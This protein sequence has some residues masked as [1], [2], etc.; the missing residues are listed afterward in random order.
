MQE[1]LTEQKKKYDIHLQTLAKLE[2]IVILHVELVTNSRGHCLKK[3]GHFLRSFFLKKKKMQ[4]EVKYVKMDQTL[5]K[6]SLKSRNS[7]QQSYTTGDSSRC[8][9]HSPNLCP[10][11]FPPKETCPECHYCCRRQLR[12][13]SDNKMSSFFF[14]MKIPLINV[15]QMPYTQRIQTH[16]ANLFASLLKYP[17]RQLI[18]AN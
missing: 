10:V 7:V 5:S 15:K 6:R 14:S 9:P 3:T 18:E 4:Q 1:T 11:Y 12:W 8:P 2:V 16:T 13:E 17:T